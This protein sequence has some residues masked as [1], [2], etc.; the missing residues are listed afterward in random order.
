[1]NAIGMY[2]FGGS[3]T[4]GHLLEGWKIDTILEMTE[5]MPNQNSYHFIKNYP[6]IKVKR[7]SEYENNDEY[8]AKLKNKNYDLLFAN[9]PCSGLSSINRNASADSKINVYLYKV[10]DIVKTIEPKVFFIENAPTL[11]S[12]GL[13]ILKDMTNRLSNYRF[14][15]IN[16]CAKNHGVAMYRR[17]TFVIGFNKNYFGKIPAIK[18]N[19]TEEVTSREALRDID[20]TYNKEFLVD[21]EQELFSLYNEIKPGDSIFRTYAENECNID[22]LPIQIQSAVRTMRTRIDN[23]QNAWD[24]SPC[25]MSLDSKFPSFTSMTRIIHPTENRDLYLREYAHIMGYPDDFIFYS[26][27]KTNPMQC[28]AQG[29]PV[30]FIRYISK[31]IKDSFKTKEFIDGDIVYI[32]QCN[33]DN[34]RTKT[35]SREE[36][37]HTDKII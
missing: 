11:T 28:I 14:L 16:D 29:V 8:L 25:R 36:F 6:N 9:P 12:L 13:P 2:I 35:Y 37:S 32:N 20:Y 23:G 15:I 22:T 10:I 3:Q 27:C 30:N 19:A 21:S 7:P 5:D 34:I 18:D 1:M 33:P 31:E 4:I 24:K 26:E 17:R